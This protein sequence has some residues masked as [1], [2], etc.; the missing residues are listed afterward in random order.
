MLS[1]I[2]EMHQEFIIYIKY[3]LYRTNRI[4]EIAP[5]FEFSWITY[6]LLLMDDKHYICK[7]GENNMIETLRNNHLKT[8]INIAFKNIE[9][10]QIE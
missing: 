6:D 7:V 3:I 5:F 4:Y 9:Y 10:Y 1:P 2:F 8:F